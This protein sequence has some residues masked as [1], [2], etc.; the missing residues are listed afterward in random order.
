L[1]IGSLAGEAPLKNSFL[2]DRS[3]FRLGEKHQAV[4]YRKERANHLSKDGRW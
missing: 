1:G 4:V 3:L 2:L